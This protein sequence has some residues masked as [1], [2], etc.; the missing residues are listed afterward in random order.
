MS[1]TSDLPSKIF[2]EHDEAIEKLRDGILA[3]LHPFVVR[4]DAFSR[5]MFAAIRRLVGQ[6]SAEQLLE[7]LYA[8][9]SFV[10][11]TTP[12]I[13]AVEAARLGNQSGQEVGRFN[14]NGQSA[15]DRSDTLRE[16]HAGEVS[17]DDVLADIL[18]A[19]EREPSIRQ[20]VSGRHK[21]TMESDSSANRQEH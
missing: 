15:T 2:S 17:S 13:A 6:A 9:R 11:E 4:N 14:G 1:P 16:E 3:T 5:T 8:A 20:S 18:S 7:V 19:A 10:N 21:A 12:L